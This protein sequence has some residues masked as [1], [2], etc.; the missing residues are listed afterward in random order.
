MIKLDYPFT[1][2]ALKPLNVGDMVSLSGRIVTGRDRLHK[3]LY[4]GGKSPVDLKDGAIF[5]CG[6][7]VIRKDRKWVI[8]AAGPTTSA[9]QDPY[10]A[11]IIEQHK[12]RVIV[13]K[14]GMGEATRRACM[15]QG[16]VYLQAVGGAAVLL[17]QSIQDVLGGYFLREFG[18]AEAMWELTVKDLPAVVAIDTR[19][20]SLFKRVQSASR[21]ALRNTLANGRKAK[22]GLR[23]G[24]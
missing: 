7:V 18:M 14:G 2:A 19:G 10:M 17:A 22:R 23:A 5:H 20:R 12:L 1:P 15:K 3:Y 11:R 21:R 8:R 16:C 6:P 13:G 9:R 4:E 24:T